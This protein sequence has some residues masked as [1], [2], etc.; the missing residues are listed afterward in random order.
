[1]DNF[2]E[3]LSDNLRY[4][5][6]ILGILIILLGLFFGARFV[7]KRGGS[8]QTSN[9]LTESGQAAGNAADESAA[10]AAVTGT[11]SATPTGAAKKEDTT[12]V[13]GDGNLTSFAKRSVTSAINTYYTALNTRSTDTV[14]ALTD[15]LS[16]ED[17]ASI[18]TSETAYSNISVVPKNGLTGDGK[19]AVAFVEY[20][21]QNPDQTVAHAGL[22]WLYM[23]YDETEQ[24]YKIMVKASEDPAI[25]EYVNKLTEDPEIAALIERVQTE[26]AAADAAEAGTDANAAAEDGTDANVAADAGT[27][28]NAPAEGTDAGEA[29]GQMDAEAAPEA[30]AAAEAQSE[31]GAAEPAE[32][33]EPE[34]S[35]EEAAAASEGEE[36]PEAVED[37]EE[38]REESGEYQAEIL[39]TCN[40]RKGAGYEFEVVTVAEQGETV[41]VLGGA[42]GGWYHV[43]TESGE[44]YIGTKFINAQ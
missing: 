24:A 40:V 14:R 36:A 8:G 32:A 1:M 13:G 26:A 35:E 22:S 21:Y 12:L 11:A 4:I 28:A 17:V 33:E 39:E 2:R 31:E 42:D 37:G 5:E 3:W 38:F 41:T 20:D 19:T 25:Q 44:G 18:E 9:N 16:E 15:N 34:M 6:L 27:D 29:A 23:Q 10:S 30:E 7:I 43:I